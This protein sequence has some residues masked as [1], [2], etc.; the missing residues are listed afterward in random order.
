[1]SRYSRYLEH[2]LKYDIPPRPWTN[3]Y[4]ESLFQDPLELASLCY[5]IDQMGI[6]SYLEIGVAG[7]ALMHFFYYCMELVPFGIDIA[8]PVMVDK[9][10]V[11]IG[12][13][14]DDET[15][16]WAED[17]GPYD[18]IFIDADHSYEAVNKDWQMYNHLAK[19]M[20]VLHDIAHE[21]LPG[22]RSVWNNIKLP[23]LE[24]IRPGASLGIGVVFIEPR[25]NES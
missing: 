25:K 11:H 5:W 24:I 13:S 19:K 22:P 16:E 1:V 6:V 8:S 12:N 14:H 7:G 15:L 10:W 23:K 20:V 3:L 9:N 17:E 18:M 2:I 21:T 4:T